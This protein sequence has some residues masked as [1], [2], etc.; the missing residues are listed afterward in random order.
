MAYN[1]SYICS[2]S[3][4][5]AQICLNYDNQN[6]LYLSV[7]AGIDFG[8]FSIG[9]TY[10]PPPLPPLLPQPCVTTQVGNVIT[11]VCPDHTTIITIEN[12]NQ[13]MNDVNSVMNSTHDNIRQSIEKTTG[14]S[15]GDVWC[16]NGEINVMNLQF[17]PNIQIP[18]HCQ[19]DVLQKINELSDNSNTIGCANCGSEFEKKYLK[20]EKLYWCQMCSTQHVY[21]PYSVSVFG[22][23]NSI[24]E[25]NELVNEMKLQRNIVYDSARDYWRN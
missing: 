16:P 23:F 22:P 19:I 4:L 9:H 10:S 5:P 21:S 1:S 20:K 2:P 8:L 13:L 11:T 15:A 6:N 7:N 24:E 14:V 3:I 12:I 18:Q 25:L 17:I